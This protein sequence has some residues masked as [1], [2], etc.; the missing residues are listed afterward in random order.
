MCFLL[1]MPHLL[2]HYHCIIITAASSSSLQEEQI[3]QKEQEEQAAED[4]QQE[5]ETEKNG[6]QEQE[7]QRA[8]QR[9]KTVDQQEE[10]EEQ[11]QQEQQEGQEEQEEQKEQEEQAAEDQQEEQ[12]SEDQATPAWS[13]PGPRDVELAKQIQEVQRNDARHDRKELLGKRQLATKIRSVLQ[14]HFG[15]TLHAVRRSLSNIGATFYLKLGYNDGAF[16]K[17]YLATI[18]KVG[19]ESGTKRGQI[20]VNFF[21]SHNSK[22]KTVWV[23]LNDLAYPSTWRLVKDR[24]PAGKAPSPPPTKPTPAV[25]AGKSKS[26]PKTTMPKKQQADNGWRRALDFTS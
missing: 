4:Q 23:N 15:Y 22:N 24:Q 3:E 5:Q 25:S 14:I 9:E 16:E 2:H 26:Q 12:K 21:Q 20:Q 8:E 19:Q 18:Q 11:E 1:H 6:R 13:T 10:Q 17:W 7:E